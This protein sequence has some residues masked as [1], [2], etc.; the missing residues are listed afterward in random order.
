MLIGLILVFL[1]V[2]IILNFI[3]TPKYSFDFDCYKSCSKKE[4]KFEIKKEKQVIT[5]TYTGE[6]KTEW[7]ITGCSSDAT[8]RASGYKDRGDGYCY[9]ESCLKTCFKSDK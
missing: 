6:S 8:L 4:N 9:K 1:V 5:N 3:K 2:V 7:K